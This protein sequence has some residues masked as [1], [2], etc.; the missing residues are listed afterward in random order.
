MS[1]PAAGLSHAAGAER[2]H[3]R[4]ERRLAARQLASATLLGVVGLAAQGAARFAHTT[5]VGNVAPER[6]GTLSA[7]L[8]VSVFLTLLGPAAAALAAGRFAP[9]GAPRGPEFLRALTRDMVRLSG[10]LAILALVVA[11]TLGGPTEAVLCVLLVVSYSWYLYC[12]GALVGAGRVARAA[13]LDVGTAVLTLV[14]VAAVV[15][16]HFWDWL[17]LPPTV[18]YVAFA[19]GSLPRG[20]STRLTAAESGR[21][22]SFLRTNSVAQ[23]ATGALI[24]ATMLCV[25]WFD[26]VHSSPFAAALALATPPNMIAQALLLV[27]VPHIATMARAH[28][29]VV[30]QAHYLRLLLVTALGWLVLFGTMVVLAPW[31]LEL[32]YPGRFPEAAGTLRVLLVVM[33]VASFAMTP[34]ALLVGAGREREQAGAALGGVVTGLLALAV[35]TPVLGSTG[36]LLGFAVGIAVTAGLVLLLSL[37]PSRPQPRPLASHPAPDDDSTV[38]G[39]PPG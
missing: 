12:R 4:K 6:L 11:A 29:G 35:A 34:T 21:L 15:Q 23:V 20:S 24:P 28:E 32:V 10:G 22:R 30:P 5:W 27:L 39:D 31:L 14:A 33:G 18:G 19:L 25:E 37:R 1:R 8:S 3:S 9:Q 36:A 7:L 38:A 17:L 2:T 26:S 13:A 16:G